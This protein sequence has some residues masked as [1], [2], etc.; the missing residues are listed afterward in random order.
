[1][2]GRGRHD[3]RVSSDRGGRVV[4]LLPNVACLDSHLLARSSTYTGATPQAH[5]RDSP[6][7][8]GSDHAARLVVRFPVPHWRRPVHGGRGSDL[9]I[10]ARQ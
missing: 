6:T 7:P 4:A 10:V 9:V 5:P 3:R 2:R 8:E 1:M